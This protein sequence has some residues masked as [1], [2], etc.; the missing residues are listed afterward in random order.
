MADLVVA[1]I[2]VLLQERD[3]RHQDTRR[4]VAALQA[5]RFPEGLLQRMQP[6]PIHS[7]AFDRGDAV[8]V[9]LDCEHETGAC[10][11]A[12]EQDRAGAT[13]PVLAADVSSG[14]S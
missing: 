5:V 11:L 4:A 13:Y 1:W 2:G 8:V 14:E 3:E 7:E 12:V 9:R 10:G 6:V